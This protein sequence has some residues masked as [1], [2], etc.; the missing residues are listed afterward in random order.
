MPQKNL[1][2]CPKCGR[3]TN[4]CFKRIS[5]EELQKA[6]EIKLVCLGSTDTYCGQEFIYRPRTGKITERGK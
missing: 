2:K 5:F 4:F 6:K 1:K 3:K